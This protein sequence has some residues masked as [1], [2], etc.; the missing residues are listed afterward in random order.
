MGSGYAFELL[1]LLLVPPPE[2]DDDDPGMLGELT[3]LASNV[4]GVLKGIM[5]EH[6]LTWASPIGIVENVQG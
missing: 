1:I 2:Y 3:S 4:E 5:Q 6:N